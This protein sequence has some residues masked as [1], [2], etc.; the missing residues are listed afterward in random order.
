MPNILYIIEIAV[1]L[2]L[3]I[4]VHEL[5]HF[6]AA[7]RF[8]VRVPRFAIGFGPPIFRWN[9]G[10]TEYSLR[11][12]PLGGFVE[13]A[14]EHPEAEGADDPRAMWRRPPWQR[15]VVFSAGVVM[16]VGLALVLFI[17]A[18]MLGIRAA[19]PIVGGVVP[20]SPAQ[21]A[22]IR[23][24]DRIVSINDASIQSFEDIVA[25]V[26]LRNAGTEFR[27]VL[28]RG[29]E[30]SGETQRL[31]KTLVSERLPGSYAPMIGVR[32]PVEPVIAGVLDVSAAAQAGLREGD[33]ILAVEGTSVE[34]WD[35]VESLLDSLP[36]GP[37]ELTVVRDGERKVLGVDPAELF[38]YDLGMEPPTM[39]GEVLDEAPAA[40]AGVKSGDRIIK[41]GDVEWPAL[42]E[43]QDVVREAGVG[44]KVPLRLYRPGWLWFPGRT[45]EAVPAV[46]L[47]KKGQQPIIGILMGFDAR[48][49]FC[50][51]YAE[52]GGSA[53]E[54]GLERGDEILWVSERDE[55]PSDWNGIYRLLVEESLDEPVAIGIRRG[56]EEK[57]LFYQLK[58]KPLERFTLAGAAGEPLYVSLPRIMN[59]LKA[60]TRG[61]NRTVLWLKRVYANIAQM[62]RG[63]VSPKAMGGPVLIVAASLEIASQGLGTLME[64]W[65]MLAVCI[66]VVNFLPVPPLDG[67]HVLFLVIEK[68]KGSPV[69]MKVRNAIW[70]AGWMGV[71]VLFAFLMWQDIGRLM[72]RYL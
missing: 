9:R 61:I 50:V 3:I 12:I 55:C 11:C 26:H 44:G 69:G 33:R 34:R 58:P 54:A 52:E 60:V 42:E 2:G 51:A 30:G 10:G 56:S 48:R 5:G 64:L 21:E 70:A 27:L 66:A 1:A 63:E 38:E 23:P 65:G 29:V 31:A 62:I 6:L 49:P 72:T 43:L 18:P 8:G 67:G 68:I 57:T 25:A 28:S 46:T 40:K 13:L 16:N 24:G 15:A 17:V 59:P 32:P 37:V 47:D 36:A 45:I 14:G 4:F 19:P 39:V 41:A 71:L 7:K 53:A 20:G 35:Q 22:D